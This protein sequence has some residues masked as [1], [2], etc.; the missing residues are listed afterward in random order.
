MYHIHDTT[1]TYFLYH[2]IDKKKKKIHATVEE[3]L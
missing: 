1:V 3:H 2:M